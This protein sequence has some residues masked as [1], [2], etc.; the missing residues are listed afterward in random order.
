MF[1][2]SPLLAMR[3][4]YAVAITIMT[5]LLLLQ[6]VQAKT[7]IKL[8]NNMAISFASGQLDSNN[9][10]GEIFDVEI[11]E[12]GEVMAIADRLLVEADGE[13]EEANY[14]IKQFEADNFQGFDDGIF[15]SARSIVMTDFYLGWLLD[16]PDIGYAPPQDWQGLSY[17]AT[18]LEIINEEAGIALSVPRLQSTDV[19]FGQ[20][21]DGTT[22]LASAGFEMPVLQILPFG[23]SENARAFEAWLQT[24][25]LRYLEL[26][27]SL[28]QENNLQGP[29]MISLS[30][31]DITLTGLFDLQLQ[32]QLQ[33]SQ[34]AYL[35]LSDPTI[36]A[37]D[38]VDY[39]SFLA[40]ETKL[41]HFDVTMR[42]LGLRDNIQQ[43]GQIPPFPILAEQLTSIL[44]SFL[45]E[46]GP[47]IAGE[48]E[49][50]MIE[51]GALQIAARPA[52]PFK[53][54]DLAMA[55]FMPDFVVRQINLQAVHSP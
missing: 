39:L 12:D 29:D 25:D 8:E 10:Q 17:Q 13:L 28:Q 23:E 35:L 43:S 27:L 9:Y 3:S 7:T 48:I 24:A 1:A 38:G 46:T 31:S 20:L 49:T 36:W 41:G 4:G 50:F 18:D 22:Y 54:E 47:M 53:L 21:P 40:A 19:S 26:A 55:L 14:I 52:T 34:D 16:D 45:P 6:P 44:N 33:A 15:M 30:R 42:D 11:L 51:G 5:G 32:T 2:L 37:D